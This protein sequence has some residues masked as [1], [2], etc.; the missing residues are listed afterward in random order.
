MI[1]VFRLIFGFCAIFAMIGKGPT[2]GL[3]RIFEP[4]EVSDVGD[5]LANA[6][7]DDAAEHGHVVEAGRPFLEWARDVP[8]PKRPLDLDRFRFQRELYSPA[9]EQARSITVRKAAQIGVSAWLIRVALRL[10]DVGRTVLY[11][12]PRER[13]ALEF[14]TM[15][16][17]PV[18]AASSYL[19]T[20]QKTHESASDTKRLKSI[21]TGYL[22]LRGSTSEDELVSVDA[23]VL[24][25][26]E[27]DRLTQKNLP[28]VEQR[29]TSAFSAGLMRNV[30]TPTIPNYGVDK[31]YR[32][33]DQRLWH[34]RCAC[35][36][37]TPMKGT[38]TFVQV[39]DHATATLRCPKC[40]KALDVRQGEWV[41][42]FPDQDR[43]ISYWAPKF[44]VPGIDLAALIER[45]KGTK[46]TQRRAHHNE[47][48]GEAWQPASAGLT[49]EQLRA[50]TRDYEMSPDGYYGWNP[51]TAGVDV[52]FSRALNVRISEH[53]SEHEKR[54]LWIGE[55]DDGKAPWGPTSLNRWEILAEVMQRFR[56]HMI[57]IDYM[58][59]PT[60]VRGFCERF[61]GRAYR[62]QWH[63]QLSAVLT[64]PDKLGDPTKLNARYLEG[65]DS[66]L[67]LV[68]RQANLL[69]VLRPEDYDS[70]MKARVLVT[71]E[72]ESNDS[73]GGTGTERRRTSSDGSFAQYWLKVGP[74]DY[75]QAESYDVIATHM[76]YVHRETGA[77]ADTS[78]ILAQRPPI[79]EALGEWREQAP[80]DLG[81][82]EP[83]DDPQTGWSD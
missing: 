81:Y 58:P 26:D 39:L 1:P 63:D 11:I 34:V 28:R 75:L 23:D 65:I 2:T 53:L 38:E 46:E 50:A 61:Y 36:E 22:A 10:A 47:D 45:S 79:H 4:P 59:D 16:I 41:A 76:L 9:G 68:R 40:G 8:E 72:L 66:T 31:P 54:A 64:R 32:A 14:S 56:I 49:D 27:Y 17:K 30:S 18:I 82:S 12:M 37:W 83:D 19:R 77:I 55:I 20:R 33:G 48:L 35:G 7:R 71:E 15:R 21:G 24:C 42:T 6:Y 43:P 51:V 62:V 44:V 67:D 69:P 60:V 52:A 80:D 70:H 3:G 5:E 13:Q 78:G 57:V 74:D 73:I 25:L 29:V